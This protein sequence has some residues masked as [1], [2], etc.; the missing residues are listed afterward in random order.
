MSTVFTDW[1]GPGPI[2][3]T[4]HDL[5]HASA[6][7]EWWY[8]NAHVTAHDGR[9]LSLF[10]AFF[11][12]RKGGTRPGGPPEFLHSVTWALSDPSERAYFQDSRVD[13]DAPRI[14]AERMRR[15]TDAKDPRLKRAMLEVLERGAV[16]LPD[17]LLSREAF[18]SQTSLELDY[19]GLRFQKHEDGTYRLTLADEKAHLGCDLV[20]TPKKAPVRHASEGVVKGHGAEDMF[21]YFI[22][23]CEVAGTITFHGR[24]QKVAQGSGWYDHEFGGPTRSE[25]TPPRAPVR[26]DAQSSAAEVTQIS[27]ASR[28]VAPGAAAESQTAAGA[29]SDVSWNWV[30]AQL[31]DGS[32][33]SAYTLLKS[34]TGEVLSKWVVLIDA[35]G[36]QLRCNDVVMTQGNAWRSTRTFHDYPTKWRLE[37]REAQLDVELSAAFDDQEF[38]T[39][40]ASPA[41]WEG[42][43]DVRG[44]LRGATVTGL[45][46]F[47]RSG[48]EEFETLED[49]FGAVGEEVRKSVARVVPTE[50]TFD[51][52]RALIA[53]E[54]RSHYMDGVDPAQIS[55]ALCKPIREITD[56]GG[57]SWR[58]Y[59]A[60]ACCDVV[61]G[62][63]RKWAQWLAMPELLHV[64]SLIVDDVQDKSTIRRGKPTCHAL[65]GEPIAINAGTAAY[66]LSQ[67]MLSSDEI[68]DARKLRLY[69][70]Y[71]EAM[72]AGHAGQAMDLDGPADLMPAAVQTGDSK[73]LEARILATHR[74]KTGAPAGAL[75]R[76]GALVGGGT[77]AQIDAVGRFFESLGLAFQV[78]DDVLNLRGFKGDL[79]SAGEDVANGTITL[80]LAK[81]MS[82]CSLAE[83]EWLSRTILSRPKEP[84]VISEVIAKLESCGALDA[85]QAQAEEL[86]ESAWARA[87]PLLAD[88]TAKVMLRAFG[89]FVLQR[90]Y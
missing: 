70:F 56:R 44:T 66:F 33:L 30:G 63:S 74:L 61:Q 38:V 15:G 36:R 89:W 39:V 3:L 29:D 54:E 73:P 2:D 55:R 46:Y 83:R 81:A 41:F 79:K 42:R 13:R 35:Q 77:E 85:T 21:Y 64:G 87:A 86:V 4:V 1:P 84:A 19:D 80:P 11:R 28:A 90:H 62:D 60:L 22:P 57:K 14:G 82:R 25:S 68:S 88:S 31:N 5:P 45:G 23:R 10:A 27:G 53:S 69:D 78:V 75:A 47:E 17:R 34:T 18:V 32:E 48:F 76:M 72:R 67:K 49:F 58:S 40:L 52:V 16:P 65:F 7:T 8:V 43:I 51:E 9:D 12:I 59:A 37:S 20:F 50:P 24:Q 71:F 26:A 6:S